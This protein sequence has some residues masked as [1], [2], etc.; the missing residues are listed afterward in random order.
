MRLGPQL[1]I[2]T[3]WPTNRQNKSRCPT[4]AHT[5]DIL[6]KSLTADAFATLIQQNKPCACGNE[7]ANGARF[8]RLAVFRPACP[9]F[10]DFAEFNARQ[11]D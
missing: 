7:R 9:A 3:I 11:S 5:A 6:R 1:R 8:F 10:F 4:I 2:K